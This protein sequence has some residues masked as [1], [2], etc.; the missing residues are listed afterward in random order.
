MKKILSKPL[1][2]FETLSGV[3]TEIDISQLEAGV[4]IAQLLSDGVK[5]SS[6]KI[7][8]IE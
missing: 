2:G 5:I 8:K 4:Y 1:K 3:V 6:R 7:V